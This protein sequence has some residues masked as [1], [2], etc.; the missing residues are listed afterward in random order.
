MWLI[1]FHSG[2]LL[3]KALYRWVF[4]MELNTVGIQTYTGEPI[5]ANIS[6]ADVVAIIKKNL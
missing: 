4:S 1:L 6:V 5:S 2:R 3:Q